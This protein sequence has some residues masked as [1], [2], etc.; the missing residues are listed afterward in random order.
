VRLF[1]ALE[2]PG[3]VRARLAT[4]IS[5]LRPLAPTIKWVRTENLHLTLKFIG[6]TEAQRLEVIRTALAPIRSR[7]AIELKFRGLGFFPNKNRP[8]VLWAGINAPPGLAELA[9]GIQAAMAE[10]EFPRQDRTFAPHLTLARL[11]GERLTDAFR[12]VINRREDRE[13][14][15]MRATEFHLIESKLKSTGAEYTTVQTFRFASES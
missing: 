5:E 6:Q 1:V 14:G 10:I 13:F 9:D 7:D 8:R 11:D 15:A 3:E 4:L 2:I 12:A